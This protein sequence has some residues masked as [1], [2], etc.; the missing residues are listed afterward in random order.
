MAQVTNDPVNFWGHNFA[1]VRAP[2]QILKDDPSLHEGYLTIWT[3]VDTTEPSIDKATLQ[4]IELE[5]DLTSLIHQ[6]VGRGFDSLVR[7][8]APGAGRSFWWR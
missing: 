6:A 1:A 3:E 7:G 2:R 8:F 5:E 4:E